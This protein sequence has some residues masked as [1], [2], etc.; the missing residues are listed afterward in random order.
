MVGTKEAEDCFADE[1]DPIYSDGGV[2]VVQELSIGLGDSLQRSIY[3]LYT[4]IL[5]D[6]QQTLLSRHVAFLQTLLYRHVALF[7]LT[8]N[9]H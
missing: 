2:F 8:V 9:F 3:L 7:N 6:F 1:A 4:K 5:L